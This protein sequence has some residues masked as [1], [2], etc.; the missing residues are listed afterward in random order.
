MKTSLIAS[1]LVVLAVIASPAHALFGDDEARRAIL[2]LR[3][4]LQAQQETQMRL[5]DRLE[6][7]AKEVKTLR[8]QLDDLKNSYGKQQNMVGDLNTKLQEMDPKLQ[9]NQAEQDKKIQERQELDQ[10]LKLFNQGSYD[11]A[12]SA[13]NTFTKKNRGS[14]LYPEAMYWLGSSY[15]GKGNFSKAI[16]VESSVIKNF[17]RHAKVP[18]AM[19]ILGMAQVDA[20]K[21]AQAKETFDQLIKRF[22]KSEAAKMAKSQL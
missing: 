16:E 7:L 14:S 11:K 13:F 5:Y 18:E 9:A 19:L 22:P 17:P 6:A 15:Y 1:S 3:G 4:Q 2:E 20:K 21:P 8:G 12:I 10:A